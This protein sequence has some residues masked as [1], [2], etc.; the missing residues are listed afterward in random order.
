[1]INFIKNSIT[2]DSFLGSLLFF[3]VLSSWYTL[4]PVRNEMAVANVDELPYLLAAGALAMLLINPLYSWIASRSNLKKIILF[5]YSFLIF[6]LMLFLLSWRSFGLGDSLWLG[7]IFYV[8]CNVY[9][10][11]VVSLFWVVIIN[12]YRDSRKRSFYGFI[13]AGGSL[14]AMFGSEISKRFSSSFDELGLELFSVSAALFLFLAMILAL[15]MLSISKEDHTIDTGNAGGGSFD[16]IKNSLKITEVRNIATYV[17]IWTALMTIQWITAINIVED[18]S[19]NSEQRLRFFATIEQVIS[20]L[21]LIVQLFFTNLIIKKIGI[22]NILLSYGIL[23]CIAF[24]MY[25]LIPSILSV[26]IVTVLLRVFE[27]GVNKPTRETIFSTFE[28]NDRYKSTVFIDTFISRFGDLSGS[29]FIAIGKLTSIAA[30]SFP[31][32]AIPIAGFLSILGIRISK[33][34]ESKDL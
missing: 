2:R 1:M 25:G 17:W 10:F 28:K 31:L 4:R 14:G 9:S 5:C 23:F 8:W 21:T 6:N 27:Y 13:M 19:Q 26:G 30:N 22:K 11:F 32:I 18:W 16:S 7:R 29:G 20:P 15:Y 33:S 24:M 34:T 3:L 12:L